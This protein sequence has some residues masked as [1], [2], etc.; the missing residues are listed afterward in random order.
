MAAQPPFDITV[1]GGGP[2][3]ITA[4]LRGRELGATVAL[5]ERGRLGGTCTNDGC[6]PTRV[7]ARTAR[8]VR[9][10]EQFANYG[11]IAA[12]P[13]VDLARVLARTQQVVYQIQEKKQLLGHLEN[14][15]IISYSGVGNTQFV[16]PHRL[17]FE[18]KGASDGA[19]GVSSERFIICAGGSSRRLT[20]PGSE[21]ALTHSDI[22][23]MTKLPESVIVV[24]GG[25]TGCQLASILAAFGS[26]VTL[27]D[28]ATRLL[29][30][31]DNTVAAI[32]TEE[33]KRRGIELIL[34]IQGVERIDFR[35]RLRQLTYTL[36]GKSQLL[37]AESVILSVGWPGNIGGL[38]LAA[39]GIETQG[40]YVK[41]DDYLR[42]TTPNIYA[43]G[44]ITGRM[45][46]VQ[47]ASDQARIAVENA[48]L[49]PQ[50]KAE[51][52]LVPH[53]GFTDP[54]YGSV[55]LTEEQAQRDYG[56]NALMASVPYA[57]LDR[58]VIDGH[59]VG[60]C[61]LIIDRQ[62]RLILGAHVVG[63][64]AVE[65]V[66]LIAAGMAGGLLVEQLADL[67]L[68]Y[69]T[70]AA[71]VGLAAR[72]L[73]REL[74]IVPVVPQWWVLKKIRGAEWERQSDT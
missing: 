56:D 39:A 30:A 69:P 18:H 25:A 41:V 46:L 21:Y 45:M 60:F 37:M 2:A 16:D 32:V 33:F 28:V 10:A 44:D 53:G 4:A 74:G 66:Q 22:W 64:Q 40:S 17:S 73:V 31:E 42:T 29:L 63:E 50:R 38:N 1:I 23:T 68:A 61:K 55:G 72:Q 71:I 15:G 52:R 26:K 62:S 57:D 19:A 3:G 43:A 12:P 65:I 6:V 8:L 70:F 11:L 47:S 35:E 51:S 67:E 5:V 58:A 48:L 14:V 49:E 9:D 27:M 24:G 7:L 59:T 13:K 20:F 34:G 36:Q 54:E